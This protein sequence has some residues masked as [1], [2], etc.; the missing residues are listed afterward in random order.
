[1]NGLAPGERPGKI[2]AVDERVGAR[3]TPGAKPAG[4]VGRSPLKGLSG[5]GEGGKMIASNGMTFA[6]IDRPLVGNPSCIT[7][8]TIPEARRVDVTDRHHLPYIDQPLSPF[9]GLRP[10]SPAGLAPGER[11]APTRSSTATL[12]FWPIR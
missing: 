1:M 12:L 7:Q 10:T 9:S 5:L 6:D 11:R 8:S 3:K 4:L 2:V